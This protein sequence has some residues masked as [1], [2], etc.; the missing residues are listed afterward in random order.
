MATNEELHVNVAARLAKAG[1]IIDGMCPLELV[2][3]GLSF[4]G[5]AWRIVARGGTALERAQFAKW[6]TDHIRTLV[7]AMLLDEQDLETKEKNN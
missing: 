7:G 6:T 3:F 1:P 5:T 2:L 4:V